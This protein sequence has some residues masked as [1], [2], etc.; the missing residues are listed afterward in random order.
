MPTPA[1]IPASLLRT[2]ETDARPHP[3]ARSKKEGNMNRVVG[4][5]LGLAVASTAVGTAQAM[6][7]V[8][9]PNG[10]YFEQTV[11]LSVKV[12]GGQVQIART[13]TNGRWY[14]N[15]TWADLKFTLDSIDGS[16][17][18]IDRAGA[19]FER[20]GNGDVYLFD[21]DTF[22]QRTTSPAGWRWPAFATA[23]GARS[24]TPGAAAT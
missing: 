11:D 12:R 22:I 5:P 16:V 17:K 15:P 4:W 3:R 23:A 9:M 1:A 19:V 8:R 20:T 24:P 7:E 18:T 14:L 6:G 2:T 21:Y 13:W 10:E